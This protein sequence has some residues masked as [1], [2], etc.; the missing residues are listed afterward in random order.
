MEKEFDKLVNTLNK[1]EGIKII[2]TSHDQSWIH[3]KLE[4]ENTLNAISTIITEA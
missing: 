2:D 1:F 4:N 3:F